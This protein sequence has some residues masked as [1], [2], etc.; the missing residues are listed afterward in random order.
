MLS[1]SSTNLQF[2]YQSNGT[3]PATQTIAVANSGGGTYSAF[4]STSWL[5]TATTATGIVVSANPNGMAPGVYAG[6]IIVTAPGVINSPQNVSVTL[7]ITAPPPSNM[8]IA[9]I[10]NSASLTRGPVSPGEIVTIFGK[11]IGPTPGTTFTV[12]PTTG[13]VDTS[14]GGVIVLFDSIPAPITYSS[15]AQINVIVPYEVDGKSSVVVRIQYQGAS[16]D[17]NLTMASAAPAAYTLNGGG[18]GPV[19]AVNQDGSINGLLNP[20][21]RESYVTIY[22][23]GGGQT[24]PAGSTGAVTPAILKKLIQPV[25]VSVGGQ[26]ATVT[27]AGSAPTLV[28]GLNQLNIQLSSN[29]PSGAQPLV[30]TV[31]GIANAAAVTLA[32]Q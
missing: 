16:A 31:G 22:F 12:N 30:I 27:F 21:S 28:D 24:N 9:S 32:V 29:T 7:T 20:A 25:F 17:A 3:T 23:T 4:P 18:S 26:P 1:L 11:G 10:V 6:T 5:S 8:S 19:V 13:K 14:L 15:A 2:S